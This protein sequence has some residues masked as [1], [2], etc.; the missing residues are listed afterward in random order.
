MLAALY[1]AAVGEHAKFNLVWSLLP[2]PGDGE[3]GEEG[4]REAMIRMET[5]R[6]VKVERRPRE[7]NEQQRKREAKF[8]TKHHSIFN[9]YSLQCIIQLRTKKA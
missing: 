5:R 8:S 7:I 3:G 1:S 6:Q 2:A 9:I 4:N